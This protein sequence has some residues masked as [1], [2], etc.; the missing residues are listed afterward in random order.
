MS[1][2]K[3]FVSL[4]Q[5]PMLLCDKICISEDNDFTVYDHTGNALPS[6]ENCD[7]VDR[8]YFNGGPT[9]QATWRASQQEGG[10]EFSCV[11]L[12]GWVLYVCTNCSL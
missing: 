9:L 6:H 12:E 1:S 3:S 2:S 8:L 4:L 5:A 10:D 11:V 7:G